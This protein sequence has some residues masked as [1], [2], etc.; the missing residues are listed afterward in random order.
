MAD[1]K[2][3]TRGVMAG[4]SSTV[5]MAESYERMRQHDSKRSNV[6]VVD[7]V[8]VLVSGIEETATATWW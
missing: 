8:M 4:K 3:V 7:F 6:Q 1:G 2:S 5:R